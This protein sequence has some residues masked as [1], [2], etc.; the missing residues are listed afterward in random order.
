MNNLLKINLILGLP[1]L[2]CYFILLP[3]INKKDLWVNMSRI[4]IIF[5]I[6]TLS[7]SIII[8]LYYIFN[9]NERLYN[10]MLIFLLGALMWP[11]M[12]YLNINKLLVILSLVITSIGSIMIFMKEKN[13]FTFML[14]FHVVFTDN[15]L[16]GIK[17][18]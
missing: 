16:W 1:I 7:I 10:P 12:L 4:Q 11:I 5:T 6:I 15:I 3:K 9:G 2:L 13:I 8:Y 14:V 17:Y 18:L